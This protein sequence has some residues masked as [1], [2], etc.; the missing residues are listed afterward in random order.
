MDRPTF[1]NSQKATIPAP[2]PNV[3]I[4]FTDDGSAIV[5]TFSD[6]DGMFFAVVPSPAVCTDP[7]H[8][9]CLNCPTCGRDEYS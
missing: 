5:E 8:A 3:Q 1:S 7:S 2:D 4:T 9:V 6:V